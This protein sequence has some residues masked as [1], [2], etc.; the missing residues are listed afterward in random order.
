VRLLAGDSASR[1]RWGEQFAS[2][3][4]DCEPSSIPSRLRFTASIVSGQFSKQQRQAGACGLEAL[5]KQN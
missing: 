5:G 1:G 2:P 3:Q 4:E